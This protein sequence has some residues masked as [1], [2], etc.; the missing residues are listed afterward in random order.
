MQ[1]NKGINMKKNF[2]L[3]ELMAVILIL[4][5]LMG[6]VSVLVPQVR[7]RGRRTQCGNNLR[8]FGGLV[9]LYANDH[10]LQYPFGQG[11]HALDRDTIYEVISKNGLA[12]YITKKDEAIWTCPSNFI[13]TAAN[14]TSYHCCPWEVA[15]NS[16][17][18]DFVV[19]YDACRDQSKSPPGN[20]TFH[21]ENH[22]KPTLFKNILYGDGSVRPIIGT[23]KHFPGG[24]P[25]IIDDSLNDYDDIWYLTY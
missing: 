23:K 13:V 2:T 22:V 3:I 20:I 6:L 10:D 24:T 12:P 18:A 15:P 1:R 8:Q 19:A 25:R 9:E 21:I 11:S 7:E 4:G 14:H 16:M 17:S 5:I